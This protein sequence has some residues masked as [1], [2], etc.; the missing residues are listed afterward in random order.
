M[1]KKYLS[2]ILVGLLT[3]GT[4]L[5]ANATAIIKYTAT[6]L[7]DVNPGEDL[8]QYSYTVSNNTFAA[9]TGFT[10]YF[11]LG[12]Y[13]FLD[14]APTA[15]NG[16]WDVL[17]WNPDP[18]LPDDGA[19]DAYALVDNASLADMFTVSFVLL[20]GSSGLGSQFYEVYYD[21]PNWSVHTAGLTQGYT[22][23]GAA[24]VPEPATML[25]FGTGLAGLVGSAMRKKSKK[26]SLR[27]DGTENKQRGGKK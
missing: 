21:G 16:D 5:V 24:P 3:L 22:P 18:L 1:K 27:I 8:W 4:A 12:L 23:S 7:S 20:G 25:L 9:D 10:I 14:P 17:T 2:M 19:Y 26:Q 15:P 11:D 13:D 6:D